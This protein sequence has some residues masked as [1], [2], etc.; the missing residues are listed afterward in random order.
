MNDC[1]LP[2]AD[3]QFK[4]S[5]IGNRQ[6]EIENGVRLPPSLRFFRVHPQGFFQ[7]LIQA[8]N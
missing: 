2:I 1:Q 8:N 6:L 5:T 4:E 3:Y 7:A